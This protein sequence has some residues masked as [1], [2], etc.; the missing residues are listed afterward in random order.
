[1]WHTS[2]A[3]T[4]LV[5]LAVVAGGHVIVHAAH[6]PTAGALHDAPASIF[7]FFALAFFFFSEANAGFTIST[8]V[9]SAM[10]RLLTVRPFSSACRLARPMPRFPKEVDHLLAGAG[11]SFGILSESHAQVH[12]IGGGAC[13]KC[14]AR[15]GRR[16]ASPARQMAA[17]TLSSVPDRRPIER[18]RKFT[19]PR[20]RLLLCR[21]RRLKRIRIARSPHHSDDFAAR[22]PAVA[23]WPHV[24]HRKK[25]RVTAHC[26]PAGR[27]Q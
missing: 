11:G 4:P 27:R 7:S 22:R 23:R 8:P 14:A 21:R 6:T 13:Q 20:H 10:M 5:Q 26:A 24:K 18:H 3:M 16:R 19:S 9:R 2:P 12:P 1:M 25:E 17:A 15:T